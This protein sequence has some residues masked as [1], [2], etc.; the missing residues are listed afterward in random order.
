[1]SLS[2]LLL[3][4]WLILVGVTWS[5]IYTV[6]T[7]FLGLFAILTGIIWLIEGVRPITVWKRP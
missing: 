5:A 4:I 1:M 7:K 6:D 2:S 3:A